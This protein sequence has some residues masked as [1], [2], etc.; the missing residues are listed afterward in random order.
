MLTITKAN[1]HTKSVE[2][3]YDTLQLFTK[4]TKYSRTAF[5]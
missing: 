3:K 1:T 2:Y 4:C 5:C